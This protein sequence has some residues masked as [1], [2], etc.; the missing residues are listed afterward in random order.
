[1]RPTSTSRTSS[2]TPASVTSARR[3]RSDVAGPCAAAR[4]PGRPSAGAPRTGRAG[5]PTSASN[6][7]TSAPSHPRST[8][9]IIADPDHH[10]TRGEDLPRMA[11]PGRP[12]MLAFGCT[13]SPSDDPRRRPPPQAVRDRRRPRRPRV[14]GRARAGVRIPGRER[15]GQDHDDADHARRPGAGRR[16]GDLARDREPPPAA[17]DVGLPARG[18]RPLPADAGHGPARV[19]R[20]SP[21]GPVRACEARGDRLAAPVPGRGPRRTARP[22]SC[23]RA[24]SRRSSSSPRSSTTRR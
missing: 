21:R 7:A 23:P 8:R 14:R 1:M 10:R 13:C 2:G 20:G 22:S 5:R 6:P 11:D 12:A 15:R 9:V 19:L 4:G 17:L 16:P 24:T 18:A 3:S